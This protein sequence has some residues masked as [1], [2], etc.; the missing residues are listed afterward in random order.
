MFLDEY[1]QS[2]DFVNNNI[3]EAAKLVEKY[4]IVNAVIAEKAI[5]YCNIF[6]MEGAKMKSSMQG[7]LEVLFEQNPKAIGGKLPEN[8]FYYE[9]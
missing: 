1:K 6:F 4:G 5:P 7:Y 3:P 2:T 8:D 9:R